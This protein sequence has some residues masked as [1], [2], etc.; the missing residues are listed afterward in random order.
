MYHVTV[1]LT[2]T[3]MYHVTVSLTSTIMYHVTVSLTSTI[4]STFYVTHS[5]HNY[6]EYFKSF[7]VNISSYSQTNTSHPL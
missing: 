5:F 6:T 1:S 4:M 2:S 7:I 3:I